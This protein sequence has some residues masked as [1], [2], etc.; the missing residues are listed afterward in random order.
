MDCCCNGIRA[1]GRTLCPQGTGIVVKVFC[2]EQSRAARNIHTRPRGI[3]GRASLERD[4]LLLLSCARRR[5]RLQKR[6]R[7]ARSGPVS[8]LQHPQPVAI[9]RRHPPR[10]P[11]DFTGKLQPCVVKLWRLAYAHNA[12]CRYGKSSARSAN[13]R[14]CSFPHG[15]EHDQLLQLEYRVS[16][17]LIRAWW[18]PILEHMDECLEEDL[19]FK[20]GK[21]V[22]LGRSGILKCPVGYCENG[23][24]NASQ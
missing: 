11:A 4:D 9:A 14:I 10:T 5:R 24:C 7:S 21:F 8:A 1:S 19:V 20:N 18:V 12:R 3:C 2:C 17:Y 23:V 6:I 13:G 22:S 15:G 16:S